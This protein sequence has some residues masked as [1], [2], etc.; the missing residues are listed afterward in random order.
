[1]RL[2]V[3]P[4]NAVIVEADA[5]GRV[6]VEHEDWIVPT[7]QERRAILYAA[8]KEVAELSELIEVVQAVKEPRSGPTS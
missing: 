4:M 1:M 6:R 8:T 3:E 5:D 2:Y 7:L